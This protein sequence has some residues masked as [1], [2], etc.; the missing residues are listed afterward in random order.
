MINQIANE[1]AYRCFDNGIINDIDK[2]KDVLILTLNDYSITRKENAVAVY[3]ENINKGYKMFFITKKVEGLS[4][5]S[6]KY[7]KIVIDD[8]IMSSGKTIENITADDVR[9]ILACKKKDGKSDVT[10]NNIRRVMSSFY[11]FLVNEDYVSKNP[12]S[13]VKA[14]KEK[15]TVKKPFSPM[16]IEKILDVCRNHGNELQIKRNVAMVETFLSTG[17]RVSELCSI[18]INDMDFR[19]G[20][21]IITGKGNKERTVFF[22]DKSILRLSEYLEYR[23]DNNEYLLTTL[24]KPFGKL[25]KTT[26]ERAIHDIGQK[27]GV[28]NCHPHRFRRTMACNAMKKGMPIEQIQALLGHESIE[29]TKIYLCI[30]TDNLAVEHKKYLG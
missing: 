7:Y 24:K 27:A 5:N 28:T 18:K 17:C 9:Y 20:E 22:N 29:T 2:F 19:K 26:V 25:N 21:C 15:K 10:L 30:D 3:D 4:D 6:L 8:F 1:V 14:I 12:M 13:N 16:E 11:T 23:Q